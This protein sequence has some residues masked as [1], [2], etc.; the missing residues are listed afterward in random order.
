[1]VVAI[2][3]PGQELSERGTPLLA[4]SYVLKGMM[5]FEPAFFR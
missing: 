3:D 1:M 5:L 4:R 2:T